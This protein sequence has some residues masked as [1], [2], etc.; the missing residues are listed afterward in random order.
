MRQGG[1]VG[2]PEIPCGF[3]E[4]EGIYEWSLDN[5][6][7]IAKGWI[8]RA[9]SIAELAERTSI[10]AQTL[11]STITKYNDYCRAGY[12]ADFGRSK[13]SLK[14]IEGP[15]YYAFQVETTV[16]DTKGGAR[17]DKEARVLDLDGKPIPR[18]YAAGEFGSIWGFLYQTA[19]NVAEALVF[20]RIAGHNA[21]MNPPL[22]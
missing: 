12:D 6:K 22:E 3:N 13:E 7:E 5:S 8:I 10:D 18:L 4:I 20:G 19:T 16:A 9:M 15:P 2:R 11:E 1:P 14:A 21:A 17:R